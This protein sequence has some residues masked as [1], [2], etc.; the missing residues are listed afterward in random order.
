M[1]L[2]SCLARKL[3][4]M[5]AAL[6]IAFGASQDRVSAQDS[7]GLTGK[8]AQDA[9]GPIK[10]NAK[11]PAQP[12]TKDDE[13]AIRLEEM[14]QIAHAFKF[15]TVDGA[16]RTPAER[17][18]DPLH[19]WTD[20]TRPF[21][22]GALWVWKSG[23]RPVAVMGIELYAAWSLEFVSLST[24]LVEAQDGQIRW[25][26]QKAG[27]EFREIPTAPAPADDQPK[28]LRQMRDLVK[29][30]S[31][32]EFY[33]GKHYA[34]RL[35]PHPIDRYAD[36]A[37]GAVDGAIVIYANGTNPEA[38]LLIEARRKGTGSPVWSYAA[39]PLTRA[40]PTLK[41]DG[42]D[43]WTSPT[44][45]HTTPEDT[46]FDVLKGRGFRARRSV[47]FQKEQP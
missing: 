20:P 30:I 17:V 5:F 14:T 10:K 24:G 12:T 47:P 46:Y 23:G 6:F 16:T 22:G 15:V 35:L 32:S 4:A 19:R 26:P 42:K 34:L 25:R 7:A 37:S 29:R 13:S 33:D 28:R 2:H 18:P 21:S 1:K 27:V 40:E 8:S 11:A 44:K 43:I 45:E 31:A 3:S 9:A 38:L 41:L 36:P 39:A